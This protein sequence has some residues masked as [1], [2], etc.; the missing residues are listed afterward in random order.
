[1][2]KIRH[3]ETNRDTSTERDT[4]IET[5]RVRKTERDGCNHRDAHR[6][7]E[8]QAQEETDAH[9][10]TETDAVTRRWR[11][12]NTGTQRQT[13]TLRKHVYV[14]TQD[15]WRCSHGC[16]NKRRHPHMHIETRR[17]R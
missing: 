16:T 11:A 9:I 13:A 3:R 2:P 6:G 14:E 4:V 5:H 8:T 12:A 7:I 10:D 15:T 1:M 17:H